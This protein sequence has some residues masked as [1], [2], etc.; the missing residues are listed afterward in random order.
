MIEHLA[1]PGLVET[2]QAHDAIAQQQ[3]R[4]T[5]MQTILRGLRTQVQT[6]QSRLTQLQSTLTQK[7]NQSDSIRIQLEQYSDAYFQEVMNQLHHKQTQRADYIASIVVDEAFAIIEG[8]MKEVQTEYLKQVLSLHDEKKSLI[9]LR[10]LLQDCIAFGKDAKYQLTAREEKKNALQI[11]KDDLSAQI[12]HSEQTLSDFQITMD[13]Q[14]QFHCDKIDG[15]CPYVSMINTAT[16]KTLQ[17]Q[18]D[19]MKSHLSHLRDEYSILEK[20]QH[21]LFADPLMQTLAHDADVAKQ[22]LLS[23]QRKIREEQMTP[24]TSLDKEITTLQSQWSQLQGQQATTLRLKEQAIALQSEQQSLTTQIQK[25]EQVIQQLQIQQDTLQIQSEALVSPMILDVDKKKLAEFEQLVDHL[26]R[27][28]QE[29]KENQ[30]LVQ[31]LAEKEKMLS[32]LYTVF[33]KELLLLVVQRNLPQIQQ[34]MNFYLEQVVEYQLVMEINK[35][36]T[37]TESLELFVTIEDSYG[38]REVASL[39]GGQKVILKLVWMMA[40]SMITRSQM[41]FLDET[42]NNL[43]GDTVSKVADLLT[44]FI[45]GK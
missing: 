24:V 45:K 27:L 38:S 4:S 21:K 34:L 25:Q 2:Q 9:E 37:S 19:T 23:C 40:I 41:L 44:N 39:S 20:E 16:F 7:K 11:R 33:S 36:S 28:L 32:D 17:T 30:V 3:Q 42:I 10:A 14:Q 15:S 13:T 8:L 12:T 6:A 29:F 22:I 43:D 18:L 5:E 1:L 31:K 35:K 26:S